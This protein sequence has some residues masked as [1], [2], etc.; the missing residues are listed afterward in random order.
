MGGR[1]IEKEDD[2]LVASWKCTGMLPC[3][4]KRDAGKETMYNN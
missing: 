3:L 2:K 1:F 4:H